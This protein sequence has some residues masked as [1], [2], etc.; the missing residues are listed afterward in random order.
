MSQLIVP[1]AYHVSLHDNVFLTLVALF[2]LLGYRIVGNMQL[3]LFV[4]ASFLNYL[5]FHFV[6][7]TVYSSTQHH[8]VENL[9]FPVVHRITFCK[10]PSM[11][12]TW[13]LNPSRLW[14]PLN[15]TDT[16]NSTTPSCYPV[17]FPVV[18]HIQLSLR[19]YLLLIAVSLLQCLHTRKRR[20]D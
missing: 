13:A 2:L 3:H 1:V 7:F 6:L 18:A 20:G 11:Y 5:H 14:K 10:R 16:Q 17:H 8:D 4:L 19:A 12:F 9:T 15:Q